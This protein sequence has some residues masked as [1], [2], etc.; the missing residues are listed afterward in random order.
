M[1]KFTNFEVGRFGEAQCA[2]YVKK[3]KKYKVIAR[4]ATIGKLEVDIIATDKEYIIFIEV[5]TR[6]STKDRLYRPGDAIDWRKR[7]NLINFANAYCSRLP[8][9]LR[10][11]APRIDA[12][13]IYLDSSGKK[14]RVCELN[15][16]EGAVTR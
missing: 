4:N 5:K 3:V 11:K 14:L 6:C 12:C 9:K 1:T 8:A 16:I 13:E 10:D 2:K 15:Y 7:Q